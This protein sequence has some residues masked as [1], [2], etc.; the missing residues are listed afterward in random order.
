MKANSPLRFAPAESLARNLAFIDGITRSG[1][2]WLANLLHHFEDVEHIRHDPAVD[3]VSVMY[4]LGMIRE[5]AAVSLLRDIVNRHT[6]E[7]AIGRNVNFR[8]ADHSSVYH[9]P[10]L[11]DY[12]MRVSGP[13]VFPRKVF[14]KL[15][16]GSR[17]SM[18]IAHDWLSTPTVQIKAFPKMKLLRIERNPVDLVNAWHSTKIGMDRMFFNCRVHGLKGSVPWF[19]HEW[20]DEFDSMAEM[21]RI[22][23]AV[24]WLDEAA[25]STYRILP[26]LNQ[27]MIFFT[28]YEVMAVK[29]LEE[30]E[31][32]A[33]FL[34][35]RTSDTLQAYVLQKPF[36]ERTGSQILKARQ[37]KL[38]IIREKASKPWY[39]R[40]V[41]AGDAYEERR[42]KCTTRT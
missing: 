13:D 2:F 18:F 24:L 38:K 30:A 17:Y 21:D 31:K 25:R 1:K 20:R 11:Q 26:E 23:R 42:G 16:R 28:A 15:R 8:F 35:T 12:L 40:L 22:I 4:Y 36:R 6:Y 37:G 34:G 19:A 3:H 7:N 5:D 14:E 39:K 27:K 33:A 10:K 41:Q 32:I 29:P 9:S